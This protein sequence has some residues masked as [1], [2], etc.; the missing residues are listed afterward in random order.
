MK[1]ITKLLLPLALAAV[2]FAQ[3]PAGPNVTFNSGPGAASTRPCNDAVY[4]GSIWTQVTNPSVTS[5]CWQT[6][7]SSLGAGAFGWVPAAITSTSG[8]GVLV[9]PAGTTITFPSGS[10]TGVTIGDTQ[11]LTSKT[12]TAPALNN[13]V[14]VGPAPVACGATCS[15]TAGMLSLLNLAAGATVTLPAATGTG[16][17]IRMKVTTTTTSAAEKILLTTVTDTIIGR[18]VGFTGAGGA[19]KTFDGSAGTYHSIQMPFAGSQ[20]SGGFIGDSI[21]CTDVASTIWNCEVAYQGGTTPTT[22]FSTSTT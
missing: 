18:A 15:P 8:G 21:T 11:T 2:A 1:T 4:A 16:N 20:P 10:D 7:N 5:L 22:P 14:I 17:V 6:G 19:S 3:G 12:L 9:I 13:P